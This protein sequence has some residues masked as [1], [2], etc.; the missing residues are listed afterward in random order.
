[1]TDVCVDTLEFDATETHRDAIEGE[2]E[3]HYYH[4]P[5]CEFP[6]SSWMDCPEC[7]WYD[8]DVWTRTLQQEGEGD[9]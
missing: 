3:R 1:M 5:S 4:C 8:S 2:V 6:I 7:G 9:A